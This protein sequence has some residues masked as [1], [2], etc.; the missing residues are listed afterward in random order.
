MRIEYKRITGKV[1]LEITMTEDL[2]NGQ[3][4]VV[5]MHISNWDELSEKDR[6]YN[7]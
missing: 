4:A 1:G 2:Q 3:E 6:D 5:A 7:I